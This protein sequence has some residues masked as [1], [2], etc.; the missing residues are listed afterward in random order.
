MKLSDICPSPCFT[1]AATF[2]IPKPG[3]SSVQLEFAQDGMRRFYAVLLE[4]HAFDA[5]VNPRVAIVGLS[6]A[7]TQIDDF[8]SEYR[9]AGS[10]AVSSAKGAFAGLAA[11]IIRMFNGLGLSAQLDLHFPRTDT[12]AGHPDLLATSLLAC[13]TLDMKGGSKD[14]D[15][16]K[17]AGGRRCATARF[18]PR[19]LN[20]TMTR[21]SHVVILGNRGWKA[22]NQLR[23]SSGKTIVADLI[24]AGKIVLNLPHPSGSNGEG[25]ALASYDARNFPS[26]NDYCDQQWEEYCL[27]KSRKG[28]SL[29]TP[30][31]EYK[32][33][34]AAR[35]KRINELRE[36]ITAGVKS[37]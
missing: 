25:V 8:V 23:G 31:L 4:N 6:P 3:C 14:F 17:T 5:P 7:G 34:R 18:L 1:D 20:P 27:K 30:E 37:K 33:S 35:W 10:Y 12:F 36:T 24:S 21:L 19:I 26:L 15:L 9:R 16:T 11:D 13:A 28:E 2:E 22:V 32:K 29:E